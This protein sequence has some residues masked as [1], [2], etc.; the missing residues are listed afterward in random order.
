MFM[1]MILSVPMVFV[2]FIGIPMF[3]V[4]FKAYRAFRE[5]QKKSELQAASRKPVNIAVC[6]TKLEAG[7]HAIPL[8]DLREIIF[9][10]SWNGPSATQVTV[11]NNHAQAIGR[12]V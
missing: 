10:H 5:D 9:Q 6:D 1:G 12:V 8:T 7:G 2:F 11:I 4:C 3:F